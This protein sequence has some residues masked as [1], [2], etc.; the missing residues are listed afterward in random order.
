MLQND[1]LHGRTFV[2]LTSTIYGVQQKDLFLPSLN[3]NGELLPV[4]FS[5][6]RF[7]SE[8]FFVLARFLFE[9][10]WQIRSSREIVG[11]YRGT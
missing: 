4:K 3:N 6:F 11:F 7:I 10:G 9:F 5:I 1:R 2:Y 8:E